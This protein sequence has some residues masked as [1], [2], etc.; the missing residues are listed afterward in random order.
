MDIFILW[1]ISNALL[2]FSNGLSL[3]YCWNCCMWPWHLAIRDLEM[4]CMCMFTCTITTLNVI[5]NSEWEIWMYCK[6][7]CCAELFNSI[8]SDIHL[9]KFKSDSLHKTQI[10]SSITFWKQVIHWWY[11][12]WDVWYSGANILQRQWW[13]CFRIVV[14]L[15]QKSH[16]II[17]ASC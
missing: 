10:H 3:F 7:H 15:L 5:R 12:P 4:V 14:F 6:F 8:I 9:P 17:L 1:Q 13:I 11:S 16:S 2:C